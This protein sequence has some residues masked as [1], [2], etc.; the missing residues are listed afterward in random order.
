MTSQI[1]FLVT[2]FWGQIRVLSTPGK[3]MAT[4][5]HTL[6][7]VFIGGAGIVGVVILRL[8]GLY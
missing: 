2:V 1:S 7:T 4:H 3:Y 8:I 5:I 6:M